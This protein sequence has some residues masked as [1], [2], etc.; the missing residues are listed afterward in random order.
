M[1]YNMNS[2]DLKQFTHKTSDYKLP[3]LT[4]EEDDNS[5]QYKTPD[6]KKYHSVTTVTGWKKS[7]FFKR[8]RQKNPVESA[9]VLRRGNDLHLLIEKYLDNEE[10]FLENVLPNEY[11]LFEQA[12]PKLNKI[13]NV[14]C[15][16]AALW[17]DLMELAGR[18]DCIAEYD[19][20]LSVIDFKGS[21]RLK[22]AE[23]I[24][25]YFMQATAYAIM[26]Q[27]RTGQKIDNIVILMTCEDGNVEVF[28][29]NPR[30]HTRD[31]FECIKDYKI[32]REL[33]MSG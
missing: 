28:E 15:Q 10:N 21:T 6:G 27:E 12:L 11:I 18:V 9:R 14:V 13:D 24:D 22:R 8:W 26:W 25:N 17:S 2:M 1:N 16:E 29:S 20:K 33:D 4:V 5:R 3:Y 7:E 31:L 32:Q 23:D 30:L 19:G